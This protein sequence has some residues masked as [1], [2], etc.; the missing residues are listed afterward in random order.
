[1]LKV[2]FNITCVVSFF[3]QEENLKERRIIMITKRYAN[4]VG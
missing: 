1:M 4:H 3:A 2:F